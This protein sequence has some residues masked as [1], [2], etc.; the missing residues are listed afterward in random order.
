MADTADDIKKFDAQLS[1]IETHL[2]LKRGHFS[3]IPLIE[4]PEAV[5]NALQIA[6]SSTRVVGLLFGCEDFFAETAA[7]HTDI[8]MSLHTPRALIVLAARAAGITP[9]DTPYVQVH[10]LAGLRVF[11][12]RARDLGM[13]GMLVMTPR[14][15]EVAHEVYSPT[16]DEVREA[17]AIVA[18]A[19]EA[20]EN[21]RG[22]IVVD[23]RFISPPTLRASERLLEHHRAIQALTISLSRQQE[24]NRA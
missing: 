18:A 11:A 3:I 15:I 22:I 4:T 23:G 7:R 24:P 9:I 20:R 5:L 21:G 1:L 12:T 13:A 19:E 16:D 8:D 2:D 14:Q 17:E 6:A 10:D